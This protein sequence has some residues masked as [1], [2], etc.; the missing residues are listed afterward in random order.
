MMIAMFDLIY[1]VQ[2]ASLTPSRRIPSELI[3]LGTRD[4][5]R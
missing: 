2:F 3:R 5:V 1:A 4:Y